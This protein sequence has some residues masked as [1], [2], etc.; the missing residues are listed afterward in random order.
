MENDIFISYTIMI[1]FSS[2]LI[3]AA[4]SDIWKFVIPNIVS[5]SIIGLFFLTSI[6]HPVQISWLSH[7]GAAASVFICG[8]I[9]YHFGLLGAGDVKL[10]ASV[11]L[12]AGLENLPL[13]IL[14]TAAAGGALSL[15]LVLVRNILFSV[16]YHCVQDNVILL[17]RIFRRGESVP[18][19]VAIAFG[20]IFHI[21][22]YLNLFPQ[23]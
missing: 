6:I 19:G 14:Y 21:K 16:Q 18:Y 13:L 3:V 5:V 17:P 22:S 7:L 4:V 8:L 12:W 20:G 2:F 1:L 23:L 11:S 9:M 10:F 15:G